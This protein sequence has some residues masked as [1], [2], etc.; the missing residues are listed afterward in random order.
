MYRAS[1]P[2]TAIF[3][4]GF[5]AQRRCR[6]IGANRLMFSTDYP[7]WRFHNP[8]RGFK[9]DL[10]KEDRAAILRHRELCC[11]WHGREFHIQTGL[12][13]SE[14]SKLRGKTYPATVERG[15]QFY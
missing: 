13:W 7:H 6:W 15:G 5:P 8:A 10:S 12:S 3:I 9:V 2:S 4:E 11:P 1:A 14:P